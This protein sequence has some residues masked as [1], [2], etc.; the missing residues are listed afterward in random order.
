MTAEENLRLVREIE[1]NRAFLLAAYRQNPELLAR[2]EPR[3][4]ELLQ[5]LPLGTIEVAGST[6][7]S[8]G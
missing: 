4:R 1:S 2:A 3:I 5:P 6:Q 8:S 7:Q